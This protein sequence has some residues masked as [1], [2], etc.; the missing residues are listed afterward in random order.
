MTGPLSTLALWYLG[1]TVLFAGL[2]WVL[3]RWAM[4]GEDPGGRVS[5]V[6]YRTLVVVA[7]V[8]GSGLFLLGA[9]D[10][11]STGLLDVVGV[12]LWPVAVFGGFLAV[13]LATASTVLLGYLAMLPA[14]RRAR[15]LDLSLA[16]NTLGVARQLLAMVLVGATFGTVVATVTVGD[17]VWLT[18]VV[19]F[20]VF[21][22]LYAVTPYT[23]RLSLSPRDPTDDEATRL[24]GACATAEFDPAG[25]HVVDTEGTENLLVNVVGVRGRRHLFV[26]RHLLD[27]TDDERLAVFVGIEA[28]RARLGQQE[29]KFALLGGLT[30]LGVAAV[31]GGLGPVADALGTGAWIPLLGGV[32]VV[33]SLA[34]LAGRLT[35]RADAATDAQVGPG[36]V[37]E[38][39]R[40]LLDERGASR[41]R[42]AV[43]NLLYQTRSLG[44]RMERLRE[45]TGASA[46]GGSES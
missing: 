39:M 18:L 20:A 44:A 26:S 6:G 4:R 31:N 8:E 45:R 33:L 21:A 15:S 11:V 5:R 38:T 32:A 2:S 37:Q 24:R 41:E 36:S 12:S 10:L 25:L 28:N 46:P 35:Y 14:V 43:A 40:W 34:W 16:K 23:T 3:S 7:A 13:G 30:A 29:A 17:D 27:V 9:Y 42:S 22:L 19:V 1:S